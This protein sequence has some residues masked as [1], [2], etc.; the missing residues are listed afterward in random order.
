[1]ILWLLGVALALDVTVVPVEGPLL[2]GRPT[3]V[4]ALVL[5]DFGQVVPIDAIEL[6]ETELVAVAPDETP[7]RYLL[8]PP[9]EVEQ[10]EL[11]V[12][13]GE[14]RLNT[15]L[16]VQPRPSSA[17]Q[18]PER[19]LVFEGE[20]LVVP[21]DG[22]PGLRADEIEVYSSEP[23]EVSVEG[24]E[25]LQATVRLSGQGARAV[26]L[27]LRRRGDPSWPAMTRVLVSRRVP[28]AFDLEP[29][30]TLSARVGERHYGPATV[31]LDGRARLSVVQRPG[32][33]SAS[34]T[35]SD[36]LGN[37]LTS[38]LLLSSKPLAPALLL[39]D[40]V[41]RPGDPAPV[42]FV[43]S[44][45]EEGR[46]SSRALPPCSVGEHPLPVHAYDQ[47]RWVAALG[48]DPFEQPAEISCV[49]PGGT[50]TRLLVPPPGRP[51]RLELRV[52]PPTLSA[53]R[54]RATVELTLRD[55][56]GDRLSADHLALSAE[57]GTIEDPRIEGATL[58]AEY[59]IPSED[60][61]VDVLRASLRPP[62][63][64]GP[65]DELRI[66]PVLGPDGLRVHAMVLDDARRPILEAPVSIRLGNVHY[67][68]STDEAGRAS[69]L[70]PAPTRTG[71]ARAQSGSFEAQAVVWPSMQPRVPLEVLGTQTEV[72]IGS[73]EVASIRI[74]HEERVAEVGRAEPL[75]FRLE[76]LDRR[77]R[78]VEEVTPRVSVSEGTLGPL[79]RQRDGRLFVP[80]RP[81]VEGRARVVT[82]RVE[83]PSG[84]AGAV[85][86]IRLLPRMPRLLVGLS[87][88]ASTNLSALSSPVVGAEVEVG[89]GRR[90]HGALF[91]AGLSSL[92]YSR[93]I[94][95]S[96]GQ[97]RTRLVLFP[98]HIAGLVRRP[99]GPFHLHAGG[100]LV[101]APFRAEQRFEDQRLAPRTSLTPPGLIGIVGMTRTLG[102][103][104]LLFEGRYQWIRS[105][106]TA[107]SFRGQVGGLGASLGFRLRID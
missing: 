34:V 92:G 86:E 9:L 31:D 17:L 48:A 43:A 50:S 77:G 54:P 10:V 64:K 87:A 49:L 88:G 1:M 56:L 91:R 4:E 12:R 100:G 98:V 62:A 7:P 65:P 74:L 105:Q 19:I 37:A 45:D 38:S 21:L 25:T 84:K 107:S 82:L 99:A 68:L 104:E 69:A 52:E 13:V 32:E 20:P 2:Q 94:E 72:S 71:I 15:T 55:A 51:E 60:R 36:D 23:V 28:L 29:G 22:V 41:P 8:L 39:P 76:L 85:T 67:E 73:G 79:E 59:R 11:R 47:G 63:S 3:L 61:D 40:R 57:L 83:S 27:A 35:V 42:V 6:D 101:V 93:D 89:L 78:P 58:R 66:L 96:V 53:D 81:P 14:N 97:G 80:W 102:D 33:T 103:V 26:L 18:V 95:T 44:T 24:E 106:G 70:F 90:L 75:R 30:G 16:P 5:D 46:W